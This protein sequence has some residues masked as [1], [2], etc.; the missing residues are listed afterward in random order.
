MGVYC[1]LTS[2]SNMQWEQQMLLTILTVGAYSAPRF[3]VSVVFRKFY[4]QYI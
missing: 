3:P 2:F 4:E 1:I